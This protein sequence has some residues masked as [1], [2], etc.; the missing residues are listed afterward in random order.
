MTDKN[1]KAEL[2]A[3][4]L[5]GVAGGGTIP[6]ERTYPAPG[7]PQV[8]KRGPKTPGKPTGGNKGG[9]NAQPGGGGA[10]AQPNGGGNTN[11][12][13]NENNSKGGQQNNENGNNNMT[14]N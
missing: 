13:H 8:V 3:G 5:A 10:G 6:E 12:Q 7:L 14:I 4:A 11:T 1:V 9:G 2:N